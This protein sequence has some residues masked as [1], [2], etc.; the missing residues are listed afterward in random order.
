M[1]SAADEM[2][3]AVDRRADVGAHAAQVGR[4]AVGVVE[5]DVDGRAHHGEGGPQLVGRVRDEPP[6]SVEGALEPIEHLVERLG[7]LVELVGRTAQRDPCREIAFRGG[8]GGCGDPV[9]RAQ[10]PSRS[11][12]AEDRCEREHDGEG[13]Q[14][15][16]QEMREGDVTLVLRALKLEVG[17]ALG[18]EAVV[19]VGDAGARSGSAPE[20]SREPAD[21]APAARGARRGCS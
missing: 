19:G 12:P 3:G 18:N 7:K 6:L 9:Q 17:V 2:L 20:S 4:G 14:R 13:D 21:V 16:L 15:V 5:H 8:A 10:H 1:S 11:D